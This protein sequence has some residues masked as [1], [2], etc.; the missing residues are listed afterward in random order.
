MEVIKWM[1]IFEEL[2]NSIDRCKD[3]SEVLES[4]MVKN[5]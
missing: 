5:R 1:S 2:E 3:V 4:I